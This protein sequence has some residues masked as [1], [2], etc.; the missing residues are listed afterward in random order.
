VKNLITE[1]R[2]HKRIPVSLEAEL[3]S[4]RERHVVFV[5]NVSQQGLYAKMALT[6]TME[7]FIPEPDLVLKI[8]LS[9]EKTLSL[10]CN[11]KWSYKI[12]PNS[13]TMRMGLQIIDPP[14][15]YREFLK[16]LD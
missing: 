12:T 11:K 13:F 16:T 9:H 10:H 6:E 15:E 4:G 3:I 2:A 1:R 7:E 8:Q 5:G 14:V